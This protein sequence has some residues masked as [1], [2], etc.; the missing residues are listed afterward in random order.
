MFPLSQSPIEYALLRSIFSRSAVEKRLD[1][2]SFLQ[3]DPRTGKCLVGT[4]CGP[5]RKGDV[6]SAGILGAFLFVQYLSKMFLRMRGGFHTEDEA[7]WKGYS[8]CWRSHIWRCP[9]VITLFCQL[10]KTMRLKNGI[11]MDLWLALK[12]TYF[13][14]RLS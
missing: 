6:Y 8:L 3:I 11:F 12:T 14:A 9:K 5:F 4:H 13:F 1:L 10:L 2:N 7:S